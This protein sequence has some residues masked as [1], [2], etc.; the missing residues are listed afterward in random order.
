VRR[1]VLYA[2][3]W[4]EY[5]R[6]NSELLNVYHADPGSE[7]ELERIFT[8]LRDVE[9]EKHPL[10]VEGR[11][12]AYRRRAGGL[13]WFDFAVLCGGPRSYVDYV[14]LA[15]RFHS[16]ILSGVPKMSSRNADAA[17]RFTWLVDV[18]YDERVKLIVS[19][20][21]QPEALYP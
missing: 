14:E 18:F 15:R 2:N 16:V 1:D 21:A 13:V 3:R 17:R 20:E 8:D 9:E 6:H 11:S 12:I 4:L 7:A 10:D 5:R 19:A